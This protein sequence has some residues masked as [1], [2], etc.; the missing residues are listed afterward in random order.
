MYVCTLTVLAYV[1]VGRLALAYAGVDLYLVARRTS[2]GGG[3]GGTGPRASA[4][5]R[6]SDLARETEI[7]ADDL[8][9]RTI[10]FK[11]F[12]ASGRNF[13]GEFF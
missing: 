12:A 10:S 4:S 2:R 3:R 13:I 9:T 6:E 1:A 11:L 7:D 5:A 8:D